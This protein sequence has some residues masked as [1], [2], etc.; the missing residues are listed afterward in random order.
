MCDKVS[1]HWYL[2]CSPGLVDSHQITQ[3]LNRTWNGHWYVLWRKLLLFSLM[4]MI[5]MM[6][7]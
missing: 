5:A 6:W 1:L 3:L 2:L 4:M 7:C